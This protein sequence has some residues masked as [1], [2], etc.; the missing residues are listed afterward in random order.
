MGMIS[1]LISI[2]AEDCAKLSKHP[3]RMEEFLFPD[4]DLDSSGNET[5]DLDKMWHALHFLLSGEAWEGQAPGSQVIMGGEATGPD[6]GYGPPG[7][8]SPSEVSTINTFLQTLPADYIQQKFD[9]Q[10]LGQNEIYP[11]IWGG[12][13]A[14]ETGE[15]IDELQG[16]LDELS[17]F[18][19]KAAENGWGVITYLS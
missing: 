6:L 15:M 4:D 12:M 3:E 13:D 9:P 14:D 18:Y 1:M 7:L 16:Y 2:S 11:N 10:L 5:V 19:R 17:A 8:I